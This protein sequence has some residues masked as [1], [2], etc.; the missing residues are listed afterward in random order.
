MN[1]LANSFGLREETL[2]LAL[3]KFDAGHPYT[4]EGQKKGGG[5]PCRARPPR[6]GRPAAAA[7]L[8]R[9]E[10]D[11]SRR[12]VGPNHPMTKEQ[13]A[14]LRRLPPPQPPAR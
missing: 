6:R 3:A 2:K 10:L 11:D 8:L 7:H 4:L 1:N 12:S 9:Q 14:L 5:Q 13:Q